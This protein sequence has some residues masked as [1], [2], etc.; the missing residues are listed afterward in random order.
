[1][2]FL[3]RLLADERLEEVSRLGPGPSPGA[4][5]AAAQ[6][7]AELNKRAAQADLRLKRLY[8]AIET[9]VAD[10]SDPGLKKRSA[11]LKA[12]R[13]QAQADSI[14]AQSMLDSAAQ[15]PVTLR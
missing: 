9:G 15:Q 3:R 8:D 14:R 4:L 7:I 1:M 2:I 12:I 5:R 10:L 13:D 11:G 6:H